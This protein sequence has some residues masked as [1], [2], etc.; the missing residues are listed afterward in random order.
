MPEPTPPAP[1][2]RVAL[3]DTLYS[4]ERPFGA[5]A[6][7]TALVSDVACDSRG[8][9]FVLLRGDPLVDR[10][11]PAVIE[12][13]PEG[14]LVGA[15]GEGL[16]ADGHMLAIDSD[17]RLFVVD[18]D[19]HQIVV[20]DPKGTLLWTIGE[21]HR[22]G[23]PFAHPSAVAFG[24]DGTLYVADG[25]G[26][27]RVHRFAPEG[28]LLGSWGSPGKGL[29]QFTTP[30]GLWVLADGRVLVADRE[31]DRVQCF[32]ATGEWLAEWTDFPRPMDIWSDPTGAVYVTDQ[33]PRLSR[34]SPDGAL[35]GRCRP[36]LNGAH[37]ICG[38]AQGRLYLAEVNPSRVTC[39]VPVGSA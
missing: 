21:R 25:Y 6:R 10:P 38:D 19:A 22:P 39:L 1:Q 8:R 35:T 15:I 17:D 23:Q 16:I 29:G 32:T 7:G 2:L 3:G 18:R 14:G 5:F 27:S 33:V 13:D 31:N 28:T 20:L 34:L 11:A 24:P 26:A 30:H 12:L 36:V 4:V 37:G 9:V